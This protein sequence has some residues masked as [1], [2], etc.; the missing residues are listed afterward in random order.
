MLALPSKLLLLMLLAAILD[1]WGLIMG[2]QIDT[3]LVPELVDEGVE[4]K[5]AN[6]ESELAEAIG[7]QKEKKKRRGEDEQE[8][9]E[10]NRLMLR[11]Q[12]T[13][14]VNYER[15]Y[16]WMKMVGRRPKS[17]LAS[18]LAYHAGDG[19]RKLAGSN[20]VRIERG[21]VTPYYMC[22][23]CKVE[24]AMGCIEDMRQN[25]SGNV[26]GDCKFNHVM[27]G[28]MD[29]AMEQRQQIAC[30]PIVNSLGIL[31]KFQGSAYPEAFRCLDNVGCMESTMYAQ[32]AEE[33]HGLCDYI[34][35]EGDDDTLTGTYSGGTIC[36]ADYAAAPRS[37]SLSSVTTL[38]IVA[39][40]SFWLLGC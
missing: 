5:D 24:E 14:M 35:P 11:R 4:L 13:D 18:K 19:L 9:E 32:L 27:E 28:N 34:P 16:E 31:A 15:E 33:C 2:L 40:A 3:D 37:V 21:S 23:G 17:T 6:G 20:C 1:H 10:D 29:H 39:A 7:L 30:C 22:V 26:R 8:Q 12:D 25:K 36:L 38:A